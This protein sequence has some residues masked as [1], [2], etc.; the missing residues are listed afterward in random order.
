MKQIY[1]FL[2]AVC[3]MLLLST[4]AHSERTTTNYGLI[5]D[6]IALQRTGNRMEV[7]FTIFIEGLKIR[8]NRSLR[9]TPYIM[10]SSEMMQLPAVVIDGRRRYIVHERWD[11]TT[12]SADTYIRRHNRKEQI[13]DYQTDVE[14]EQWM[15]DSELILREEWISCHDKTLAEADI[16]VATYIDP[17][18]KAADA[19][20]ASKQAQK[21]YVMP[22]TQNDAQPAKTINIFFPVNRST[23][24]GS[25]MDNNTLIT[26]LGEAVK[27]DNIKTIHLMGYA[28]PEGGYLFNTNLAMHRAEAVHKHL[29]ASN[30]SPDIDITTEDAPIDWQEL[31]Q[32]LTESTI[33]HSH[34]IVAIIDNAD[35]KP[36]DKNKVIRERYPIVYE[37][38]LNNW[39]PKLRKTS[40]TI[41]FKPMS[42]DKAKAQLNTNPKSLSLEDMYMVALTYQKGSKEFCDILLLAADT[43]PNSW[44]AR[45]N[46]ANVAMDKGD[47]QKAEQYLSGIPANNPQAMNSR[48]ILAMSQGKYQE[49]MQLFQNAEKAGVSEAAYNISLLN[50]L[51]A[52]DR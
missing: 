46:A 25:F 50:K 51:I 43:Y 3:L 32:W 41:D 31:K 18:K 5:I 24:N 49:A 2:G 28:S 48:G 37:F 1:T 47:Y 17:S 21:A 23:I 11:L 10:G 20:A 16:P 13:I 35:I 8:P 42:I 44:Q 22:A 4:E 14:Y 38:M 40:I 26:Q 36:A 33:D 52:A 27:S 30:L 15:G 29:A 12:E 9:I 45:I 7:D 19:L 6:D 39:Y 34:D